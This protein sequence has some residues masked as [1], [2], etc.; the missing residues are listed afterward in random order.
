MESGCFVINVLT[1]NR[2]HELS[3]GYLY[4]IMQGAIKRSEVLMS[5]YCGGIFGMSS[6]FYLQSCIIK[7][8]YL[9][10]ENNIKELVIL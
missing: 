10:R 6:F 2:F 9:Y 4:S 8:C 5:A 3:L 1:F 7:H